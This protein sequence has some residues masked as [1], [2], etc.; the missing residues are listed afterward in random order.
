ARRGLAEVR[1]GRYRATVAGVAW[2]HGTLGDVS[3]D[4]QG[5][6]DRLHVVRA[7]RAVAAAPLAAGEEVTLDLADGLLM[8]RP[9]REGASRGRTVAAARRGALVEIVDLRG[10]VP[11][12][13]GSV[14]VLT[15]PPSAV[16]LPGT[17]AALGRAL[18]RSTG[19]LLAAQGLEAFHLLRRATSRPILRFAI[20]SACLEASRVGVPSTVVVLAPELPR[21][22]AP[23]DGPDPPP[24]TVTRL[25]VPRGASP[26][27]PPPPGSPAAA[28]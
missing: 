28:A 21:F 16:A 5:R 26:A 2:L 27:R 17:V 19:G 12:S 13:R 18:G 1:D 15:V 9:G 20:P 11:L 24:I 7:T 10:I 14:R 8:A 25:A 4:L 23:F 3:V 22:L 6:L